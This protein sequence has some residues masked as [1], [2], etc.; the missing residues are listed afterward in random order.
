VLAAASHEASTKRH[1]TP[2][3]H[4]VDVDAGELTESPTKTV[5]RSRRASRNSAPPPSSRI[6]HRSLASAC[7]R[8]HCEGLA[9]VLTVHAAQSPIAAM[10]LQLY[11]ADVTLSA[12]A[13]TSAAPLRDAAPLSLTHHS[14]PPKS[15]TRD[16]TTAAAPRHH[17]GALST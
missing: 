14:E 5:R 6:P 1:V 9:V 15:M 13:G 4:T 8:H 10:S 7:Q 16:S 2:S 11:G 17:D 3:R 12:D